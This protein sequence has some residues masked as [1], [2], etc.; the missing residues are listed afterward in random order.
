MERKIGEIFEYNGEWYQCVENSTCS[1]EHCD[2]R[3]NNTSGFLCHIIN[4]CLSRNRA[5]KKQ[6]IYKKL[7]KVGEP[8]FNGQYG[9]VLQEYK[10]YIPPITPDLRIHIIRLGIVGIELKQNKEYMEEGKLDPHMEKAIDEAT[11]KM[12]DEISKQLKENLNKQRMKPF[13]LEAAK[14]G[15]PVCTRNGR[16]ARIIC[17]DRRDDN[18]YNIVAL[19]EDKNREEVRSYYNDG[20]YLSCDEEAPLDLM[21]LP[22]KK[23]GWVNVYNDSII[24]DTKEEALNG[25]SEFRGYIDTV[26][27]SWEE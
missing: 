11:Q 20:K 1:C 7:E 2:F 19:I 8:Y 12:G 17:F 16:K 14:A 5:D 21:M 13:N 4:V 24:Y 9:E 3:N 6:V 27:V 15:R 23:E 25:R 18:N 26:K 10:Y 22:E